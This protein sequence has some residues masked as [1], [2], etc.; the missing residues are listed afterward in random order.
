MAAASIYLCHR[1]AGR[2]KRQKLKIKGIQVS[3]SE[4][5]LIK[6]SFTRHWISILSSPRRNLNGGDGYYHSTSRRKLYISI[7][8]SNRVRISLKVNA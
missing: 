6:D 1:A 5:Y 4:T 8:H 7:C 3:V 2:I